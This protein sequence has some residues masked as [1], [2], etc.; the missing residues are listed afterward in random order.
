[1]KCDH[2]DISKISLETQNAM[3]AQTDDGV[4]FE[5]ISKSGE[6]CVIGQLAKENYNDRERGK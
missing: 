3:N 6:S 5:A 4:Y 2:L 1:M